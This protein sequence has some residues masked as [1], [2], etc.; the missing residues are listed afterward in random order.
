M[1]EDL[2]DWICMLTSPSVVSVYNIFA[3]N[4]NGTSHIYCARSG[5][6]HISNPKASR[7]LF[8][9]IRCSFLPSFLL[10]FAVWFPLWPISA[11]TGRIYCRVPNAFLMPGHPRRFAQNAP[12]CLFS[13]RFFTPLWHYFSWRTSR[14]SCVGVCGLITSS[15]S[16]FFYMSFAY[17]NGILMFEVFDFCCRFPV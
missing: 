11:H 13:Y 3:L 16:F 12:F 2:R 6:Y 15:F 4:R 1:P 8:L 7:L 5:G 9:R 17:V 14:E 10:L